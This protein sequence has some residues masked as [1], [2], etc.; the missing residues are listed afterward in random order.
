MDSMKITWSIPVFGQGLDSGRGDLVRARALVDALRSRG[1]EVRVVEARN[2]PGR[3]VDDALYRKLL[4]GRL[5]D[6]VRLAL[7]DVAWWWRS[8]GHGRRVAET[9]EDQGT[10]VLVETQAHGVVSGAVAARLTGLPLVLD[11]VSPPTE[12]ERLGAGLPALGRAAFRKQRDAATLLVAPSMRIRRLLEAAPASPPVRVIPNGVDLE[13]HRT[14]APDGGR[15][16]RG[17]EAT[18]V[19]GFVGS[20]QPWHDATLLVR[21]FAALPESPPARLLLVGDGPGRAP[22]LATARELEVESRIVAPG[23]VPPER[24][25]ALLA[26][27]DIGVLPGTNG[28]GHPMKLLEYAAAGLPLVAPDVP[29]VREL[30]TVDGVSGLLF[31]AG[32]AP[33]LTH[34]LGRLMDDPELRRRLAAHARRHLASE[35]G[36][37]GRGHRL[38]RILERVVAGLEG[39]GPGVGTGEAS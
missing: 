25:P 38:E 21:A 32:D 14:V 28:Y 30:V 9:A 15:G 31:P 19:I 4:A 12:V 27:C 37:P 13:G 8:R 5:P 11:D 2:R 6:R 18:V 1:H 3:Q 23:A 34:A 24:I 39:P 10:D 36:W 22:A 7:R 33:A 29:P 35:S 16:S 17:P 26:A 20:F